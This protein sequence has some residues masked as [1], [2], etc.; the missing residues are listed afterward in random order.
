MKNRLYLVGGM[1]VI[2]ALGW[3][4]W[5]AVRPRPPA[6]PEPEYD[7][8]PLNYWLTHFAFAPPPTLLNDR[9]AVPF[10]VRALKR[11]RSLGAA[12][13]RRHVWPMLPYVMRR[14]SLLPSQGET[15]VRIQAALFLEQMGPLAKPAIPALIRA[16]KEDDDRAVRCHAVVALGKVG[17]RESTV[18]TALT[19]ALKDKD[20]FVRP[21]ATNAPWQ[22]D[23]AAAAKA[24]FKIPLP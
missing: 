17:E 15:N 8:K 13:Y 21:F 24:G 23:P 20:P 6:T 4:A 5:Q 1:L 10:L 3:A 16:L 12:I 22:L 2:A 7:G 14:R 18:V 19:E 9:N 11:D